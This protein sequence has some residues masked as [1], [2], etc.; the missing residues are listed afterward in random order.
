MSTIPG[1]PPNGESSTERCGSVAA[2][3]RSCTRR[4]RRPC[5]RAFAIRLCPRKSSMSVGKIVKT[6]IRMSGLHSLEQADGRIDDDPAVLEGHDER[7][8]DQHTA[9]DLE[10]I[11]RWIRD[12]RRDEA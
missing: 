3:R 10:E 8:R 12:K 6:S 11:A 7:G 9:V 4:S 2:E 1:P 5:S